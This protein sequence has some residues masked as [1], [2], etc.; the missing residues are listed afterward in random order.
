VLPRA[1]SL[2][3]TAFSQQVWEDFA[4]DC[5]RVGVAM[6]NPLLAERVDSKGD[7]RSLED[8]ARKHIFLYRS[9]AESVH[10]KRNFPVVSTALPA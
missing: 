5:L 3:G 9:S 1:T 7:C 4:G 10:D 2:R 6:K 8:A